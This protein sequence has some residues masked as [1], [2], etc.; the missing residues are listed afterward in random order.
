[1]VYW[2]FSEEDFVKEHIY[3]V[4]GKEIRARYYSDRLEIVIDGVTHSYPNGPIVKYLRNICNVYLEEYPLDGEV[5]FKQEEDLLK[6][7][8]TK[9]GIVVETPIISNVPSIGTT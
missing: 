7:E 8:N 3:N 6:V 5:I 4:D 2:L 9:T 1:M